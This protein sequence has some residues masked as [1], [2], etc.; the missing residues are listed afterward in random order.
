MIPSCT[1]CRYFTPLSAAGVSGLTHGLCHRFP[2][3]PY[4]PPDARSV[5]FS[6]PLV[7]PGREC[8][9][10]G[11]FQERGVTPA[12]PA[13]RPPPIV[14]AGAAVAAALTEA[15]ERQPPKKGGKR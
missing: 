4:D 6:L 5:S 9:W 8:E 7:G 15:A 13:F 11:E 14:Q 2:P 12:T 1:D 10:C 3:V